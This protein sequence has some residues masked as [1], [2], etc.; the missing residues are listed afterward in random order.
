MSSDLIIWHDISLRNFKVQPTVFLKT[1]KNMVKI[2]L[3]VTCNQARIRLWYLW[4][5]SRG[6]HRRII[7]LSDF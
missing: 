2:T 4:D 3:R 6:Q 1:L 5:T 7:L